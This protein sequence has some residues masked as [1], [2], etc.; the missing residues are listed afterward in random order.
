[1]SEMNKA[2]SASTAVPSSK[3]GRWAEA[4]WAPPDSTKNTITRG[5]IFAHFMGLSHLTCCHSS[6]QPQGGIRFQV[7]LRCRP[8]V[9]T[10]A[11]PPSFTSGTLT[12]GP[13]V[14]RNEDAD[15]ARSNR[16]ATAL[17]MEHSLLQGRHSWRRISLLRRYHQPG[18]IVALGRQAAEDVL[19]GPLVQGR[20]ATEDPQR[21]A[22]GLRR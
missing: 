11:G 10:I 16:P 8:R 2:C 20:R 6:V 21:A 4:I 13:P 18:W 1:M 14:L 7:A 22:A 17:N 15:R 9:R 5:V 19:I 12:C 3:I